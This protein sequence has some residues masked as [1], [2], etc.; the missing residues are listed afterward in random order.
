MANRLASEKPHAEV[1][2]SYA[3]STKMVPAYEVDGCLHSIYAER[4]ALT[5]TSD[6]EL[7]HLP[8]SW[9]LAAEV[10]VDVLR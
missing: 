9:I 2:G 10:H 1:V 7:V 3:N 5:E 6:E 8:Q 4:P